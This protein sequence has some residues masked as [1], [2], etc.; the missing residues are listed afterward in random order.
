MEKRKLATTIQ[1]R[2]S[3]EVKAQSDF[4][5]KQMGITLSDGINMFLR[6]VI[7]E[8]GMPFQPRTVKKPCDTVPL[9]KGME[10]DAS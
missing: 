6:Q 9:G 4:I 2:T 10:P 7:T 3:P 1:I 5:F 8:G